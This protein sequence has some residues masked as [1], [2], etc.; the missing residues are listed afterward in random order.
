MTEPV[1]GR[2]Y[3]RGQTRY[4]TRTRKP[5]I[6]L[7]VT[8]EGRLVGYLWA[9][10]ADDG[11]SAGF[12]PKIDEEIF[13]DDISR[14]MG[15]GFW[16]DRLR[17]S[18]QQDLLPRGGIRHWIG[19]SEHS[20]YGG[21]AANAR[22]STADS[23]AELWNQLNPTVPFDP[24]PSY[25]PLIQ[26]GE[27]PDGSRA[28]PPEPAMPISTYPDEAVGELVYLTASLRGS[29][30]G[31]VWAAAADD[32]AGWLPLAEAGP[33]G[34]VAGGLWRSRL[35]GAYSE[36]LTPLAALRRM[37]ILRNPAEDTFGRIEPDA[38]EQ[39]IASLQDLR[40]RSG[41]RGR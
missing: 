40:N 36:G 28:H 16:A 15:T 34:V 19:E 21:V 20:S 27:Y 1:R 13:R 12:H 9:S 26:D 3:S 22:E 31:Y 11:L 23:S 14:L 5:V 37:R 17:E 10:A 33:D 24:D 7:P 25:E 35:M 8:C 38:T 32:A 2:P 29:V 39:R 6:Y 41:Y 18:F 30:I 4:D